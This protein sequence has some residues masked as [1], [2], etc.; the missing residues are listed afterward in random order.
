MLLGVNLPLGCAVLY[1][2]PMAPAPRVRSTLALLKGC[3]FIGIIA[4][5]LA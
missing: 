1:L 3:Y 5:W 4:L 2:A